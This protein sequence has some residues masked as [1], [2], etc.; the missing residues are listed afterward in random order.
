MSILD[1]LKPIDRPIVS[2]DGCYAV[3][4]IESDEWVGADQLQPMLP[5]GW[6]AHEYDIPITRDYQGDWVIDIFCPRCDPNTEEQ[7]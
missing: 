5:E 2:C 6:K 4:E 3:V 1:H 7:S